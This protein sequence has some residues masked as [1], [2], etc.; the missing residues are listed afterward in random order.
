M[1]TDTRSTAAGHSAPPVPP[2]RESA[3]RRMRSG[4]R[5]PCAKHSSSAPAP[6]PGD[7]VRWLIGKV[8]G[9]QELCRDAVGEKE[10]CFV[11]GHR[12]RGMQAPTGTA[13][14]DWSRHGRKERPRGP[15]HDVFRKRSLARMRLQ[16]A[17]FFYARPPPCPLP[18]TKNTAR[19][20]RAAFSGGQELMSCVGSHEELRGRRRA[21]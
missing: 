4:G 15:N 11:L 10:T 12:V 8:L 20:G 2:L 16:A 21:F 6:F 9:F 19:A 5:K 7:G 17:R 13:G 18:Q 1:R 14:A 3:R